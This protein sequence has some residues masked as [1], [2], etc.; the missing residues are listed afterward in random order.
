MIA[1]QVLAYSANPKEDCLKNNT[2]QNKRVFHLSNP[3]QLFMKL[4]WE[5]DNL[6]NTIEKQPATPPLTHELS[7]Y[8]AYNVAVTAWHLTDW[9]WGALSD[10]AK[11]RLAAELQFNISNNPTSNLKSFQD[12]IRNKSRSLEICWDIAN[13]S[14]HFDTHKNSKIDAKV[15]WESKMATAG[16]IRAGH[17]IQ[18]FT[19]DFVVQW[20]NCNYRLLDIY[21][22]VKE[23]WFNFLARW[24][25]INDVFVKI[26][27]N[28][29]KVR[30]Q[31][32]P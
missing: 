17:P 28:V 6:R 14:K 19:Y 23:F 10:E 3:K 24:Q 22:E 13:G 7:A 8:H 20:D 30:E 12:A 21:E 26:D 4:D 25:F 11:C 16:E 31:K 5:I 15:D 1:R 2:S 18:T 9:T 29:I 27:F 32:Q